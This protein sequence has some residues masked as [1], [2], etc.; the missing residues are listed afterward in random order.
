MAENE[1][2]YDV[3]KKQYSIDSPVGKFPVIEISPLQPKTDIPVI[4]APG[5]SEPPEV[6]EMSRA[7]MAA[8]GRKSLAFDHP[9]VGGEVTPN[10]DYPTPELRKALAL[11]DLIEHTGS[12]KVDVVAHSEG[13]IYSAIAASLKPEKFRNIVLVAPGGMIGKDT[14][15][16]LLGRF[17]KKVARNLTQGLTDK[18]TSKT[19]IRAH[20]GAA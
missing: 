12:E 9:R 7:V 1:Q 14:L 16:A 5:W 8:R 15:P 3:V 6:F 11:L 18:K 4:I 17:S 2:P 13:A 20:I 10:P 19:V